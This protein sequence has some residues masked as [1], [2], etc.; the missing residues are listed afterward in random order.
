MLRRARPGTSP[1]AAPLHHRRHSAARWHQRDRGAVHRHRPDAVPPRR[2]DLWPRPGARR[3]ADAGSARAHP[4]GHHRGADHAHPRGRR[5][6]RQGHGARPGG[7]LAFFGTP[8]AARAPFGTATLDEVYVLL[9]AAGG[10][11]V[12]VPLSGR[13][14]E[15]GSVRTDSAAS[16]ATPAVRAA[17][18]QDAPPRRRRPP[19]S[20]PRRDLAVRQA[21]GQTDRDLLPLPRPQEPPRRRPPAPPASPRPQPAATSTRS[22]GSP[23]QRQQP[24]PR[25]APH[26]PVPERRP[27]LTRQLRTPHPRHNNLQKRNRCN[28]RK[29]PPPK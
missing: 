29:N 15:E 12:G 23:P 5:P 21:S 13:A 14:G 4:G 16:P 22:A 7:R 27:R 26:G 9:D 25:P 28:D 11:P 24:P 2:A 10:F 18:G 8:A 1:A 20:H 6:V 19:R 3:G 17:V